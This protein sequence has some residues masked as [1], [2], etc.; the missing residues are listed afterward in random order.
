MKKIKVYHVEL[1]PDVDP[2]HD[3]RHGFTLE[4]QVYFLIKYH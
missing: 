2:W 4:P 3:P 1:E